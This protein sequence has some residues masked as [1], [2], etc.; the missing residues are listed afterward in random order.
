V[1]TIALGRARRLP[2]AL[3][4]SNGEPLGLASAGNGMVAFMFVV[5][6]GLVSMPMMAD[7]Q[8]HL[9]DGKP[10]CATPLLAGL[11]ALMWLVALALQAAQEWRAARLASVLLG[12][13]RHADPPREGAWGVV[14]GTVARVDGEKPVLTSI[15]EE[16]YREG[17]TPNAT[18]YRG[19]VAPFA[20]E[21]DD[22]RRVQVRSDGILW[23][24]ATRLEH[25][26]RS[27][28]S[29][30]Q[31]VTL[32]ERALEPGA[33]VIVAGRFLDGALESTSPESLLAFGAASSP[34]AALASV[35]WSGR[36]LRI[37]LA[38]GLLALAVIA[39]WHPGLP[40]ANI[41]GED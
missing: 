13:P 17:S 25:A 19:S 18:S 26:G 8:G 30:N 28:T 31:R 33:S 29:V 20:I 35:L 34:R 5:T 16:E 6:L 12:A 3:H 41:P 39:I 15:F 24:A 1:R 27:A 10:P 22:D 21:I 38:L 14:E 2:L 40:P 11:H 32:A 7:M 36:A 23:G 9:I 4:A 37:V